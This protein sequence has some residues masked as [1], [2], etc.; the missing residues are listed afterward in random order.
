MIQ[1]GSLSLLLETVFVRR[2]LASGS[3]GLYVDARPSM[4]ASD[5]SISD[6]A[7]GGQRD[8]DNV[9]YGSFLS[10]IYAGC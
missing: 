2:R 7:V 6:F 8:H 4:N 5:D 10:H 9:L 3:S 1:D